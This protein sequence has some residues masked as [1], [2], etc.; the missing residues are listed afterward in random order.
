MK[1]E[2]HSIKEMYVQCNLERVLQSGDTV[3]ETAWI[4]KGLAKLNTVLKIRVG[5]RWEDGWVVSY[6]GQE[7]VG[8]PDVQ[9]GIRQHKKRTG[10]SLPKRKPEWEKALEAEFNSL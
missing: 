6:V 10:D 8:V 9:R 4:P 5:G 3:Y 7:R 1:D 2:F